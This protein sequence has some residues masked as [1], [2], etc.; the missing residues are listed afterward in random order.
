VA[1]ALVALAI[2]AVVRS[3]GSGDNTIQRVGGHKITRD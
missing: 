2:V 3:G 1:A